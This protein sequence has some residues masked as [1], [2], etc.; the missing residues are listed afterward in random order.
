MP[1][2]Y[3]KILEIGA[4]EDDE[5]LRKFATQNKVAML[6]LIAP[7][8]PLKVSPAAY[9]RAE[10]DAPEEFGVESFI[11]EAREKE[12]RGELH[13]LLHS[14][15]GGVEAAYTIARALR[16]NFERVITFVPQVAASGATL[17]AIA[18]NEIVMGEIS[19]LSPIDVQVLSK[20]ERKSALAL[21][22]GF[23]KLSEKFEKS[24]KEDIGY[25]YR[26][27][28]E[29]IDIT[30]FEEW[31]GLLK[32]MMSYAVELLNKAGYEEGKSV[33]IAERLVYGFSS[34]S[35]VIHF[36][37][38]RELELK[39]RSYEEFRE[40]WKIMRRW[41]AKYLLEESAIHHLRYVLPE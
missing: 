8:A 37:K 36:A 25:P 35:E 39:V 1:E 15:G 18:S 17:I 30:T 29:T 33:E 2:E 24:A 7:Y 40:E 23:A 32:E 13:L 34:H 41:L 21:L 4:P 5:V 31:S 20:G 19:R 38:A 6:A 12:Y 22:R 14:F 27:L 28:I 26:H 11:M 9:L 10:L 16:N 3:E